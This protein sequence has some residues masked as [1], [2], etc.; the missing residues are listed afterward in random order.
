MKQVQS[1]V[2]ELKT[3]ITSWQ[4]HFKE[5]YNR[6]SDLKDTIAASERVRKD[7]FNVCIY[8]ISMTGSASPEGR[9][10]TA[11]GAGDQITVPVAT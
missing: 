3:S 5:S 7:L 4:N 2:Q 8:F 9:A 10:G 11:Y 1:A 6:L